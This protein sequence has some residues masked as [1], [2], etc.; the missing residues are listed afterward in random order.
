[1][2]YSNEILVFRKYIS[3]ELN[4]MTASEAAGIIAAHDNSSF[5]EII[6]KCCVEMVA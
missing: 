5:S 2:F 6:V 1:M 3:N 4:V